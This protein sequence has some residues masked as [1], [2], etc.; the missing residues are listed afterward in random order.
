MVVVVGKEAKHNWPHWALME[1]FTKQ[2]DEDLW[3]V[4]SQLKLTK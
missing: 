1:Q 3:A 4:I 2:D